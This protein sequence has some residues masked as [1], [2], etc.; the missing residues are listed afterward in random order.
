M[1]RAAVLIGVRKAHTLPTLQAVLD[2]VKGMEAW[3]IA[4]GIDTKYIKTITDKVAK[5][6]AQQII[7][8]I[9]EVTAGDDLDQLIIYFAG[10]GV[11]LQYG[12]YWLLSNAIRNANEAVN[13]KA[14]EERARFGVVPH[15]VFLS[16]ACRTAASGIAAQG[17]T[18]SVIFSNPTQNI[19]SEKAVDLFFATLLGEPALEIAD[20]NDAA[21]KFKAVYTEVL[22]EALD[23]KIASALAP[24][25]DGVLVVRPRPL[26]RFLARELPR[27]VFKATQ[28]SNPRNQVP[29]ARITSDDTAWLSAIKAPAAS[30][31]PVP[32]PVPPAPD[33][34]ELSHLHFQLE[35]A[36][37]DDQW[38]HAIFDEVLRVALADNRYSVDRLRAMVMTD[39]NRRFAEA[40]Q[41][42]A[43]PF[44]PGHFETGCGFKIRG[45][46]VVSLDAPRGPAIH[47]IEDG[48]LAR[49]DLRGAPCASVLLT[50]KDGRGALL[51]A[52]KDFL[53]TLTF[54][55]DQLVDV[56]YE[57]SEHSYRWGDF[58]AKAS[59]LRSLRAIVASSSRLL[60]TFRLEG[61]DAETLARRMQMAKGVDP[62]LA[63][64]A[65]HAYRDQGKRDR[66]REMATYMQ[67]DLG[68][69]LFDIALLAGMIAGPAGSSSRAAVF[70]FLPMLAQSW[71]MMTAHE[72]ALPATL[73]N[74][75]RRVAP[76]SLWT[77]YDAEGVRQIAQAIQEGNVR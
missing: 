13:V 17:I 49:V 10:H 22:L 5:V 41:R 62:T 19:G 25:E 77:L 2:G 76:D 26:K 39:R 64:Y 31:P 30:T 48:I 67:H 18:G 1:K 56:A 58:Q 61:P 55:G 43:E 34:R 37:F 7:D 71:A 40:A 6:T 59:E 38:T 74:I 27:R 63:L 75:A 68:I 46:E 29:D 45:T 28:G 14:S 47:P 66:I 36:F 57:P 69:C 16:D 24:G 51:P 33:P 53:A 20:P 73:E 12:E 32:D 42:I 4:Q 65:A 8:A 44:G 50:F 72:V 11:N 15:V 9:D 70:P 52:I 3:A 60:G 35:H 21:S 54:E 23:G